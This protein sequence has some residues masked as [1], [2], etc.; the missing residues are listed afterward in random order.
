MPYLSERGWPATL[1]TGREKKG[2]LGMS[3]R[4]VQQLTE[5]GEQDHGSRPHPQRVVEVVDLGELAPE[6]GRPVLAVRDRLERVALGHG[7]RGVAG[8][9][10][11][12]RVGLL[13]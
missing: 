5:V 9:A 2:R 10:A 13:R 11:R 8:D 4:G 7:H 12:G 6:G 1:T 3:A